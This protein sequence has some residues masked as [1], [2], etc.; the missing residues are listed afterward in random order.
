M[1]I[2]FLYDRNDVVAEIG[3]AA[4]GAS[5]LRSLSIDEPFVRQMGIGNEQYHAD[6]LGSSLTLSNSTGGATATY[7]YEP[8]GK[9][10]TTGLSFNT[11]QYTG[12]EDDGNGLSYYRSRYYSPR[13]QRFINEDVVGLAGGLN[14]YEY[15]AGNPVRFSDPTGY[16]PWCLIGSAVG[17]GINIGTQLSANGGN[18]GAIDPQSVGF[19]AAQGFLGGGIG[20]LTGGLSAIANIGVSTVSSG[21]IA[22]GLTAAQNGLRS[23]RGL[24]AQG[25]VVNSA[26][27]NAGFGGGGTIAGLAVQNIYNAIRIANA[28]SSLSGSSLGTQ[29]LASYLTSTSFFAPSNLGNLPSIGT[30]SGNLLSN[31]ISNFPQ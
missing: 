26:L 21:V 16:C 28:T 30:L 19:A 24:P 13:F 15:T 20:S 22:A 25:S 12:R 5:Y 11:F 18:W 7:A 23:C 31:F 1:A 27:L 17:A 14:F 4:V 6:A 2:Q 8:F 10:T 29:L 9:K 3:G